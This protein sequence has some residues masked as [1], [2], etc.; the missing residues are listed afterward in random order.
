MELSIGLVE[1]EQLAVKY[2]EMAAVE[3]QLPG[4]FAF[5]HEREGAQVGEALTNRSIF[6][7]DLLVLKA[8]VRDHFG[9]T[10]VKYRHPVLD[11]AMLIAIMPVG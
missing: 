4:C 11:E 5:C 8:D 10:I 9:A 1:Q 7:R 3:R 6:Q 2:R